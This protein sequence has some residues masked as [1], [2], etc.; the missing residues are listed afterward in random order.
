MN[1]I[2]C[3]IISGEIPARKLYEDGEFIAILDA[4]PSGAGHSLI[5]PKAH[6]DD[7]LDMD[8]ALA[9]RAFALASRLAKKVK[10]E[11]DC[12]GVNILQNNREAAGQTVGHFHVHVIPRH[13]GDNV[14]I[15]WGTTKMH[16]SEAD[17]V[18]QRLSF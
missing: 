11:L 18:S 3:K 15:K 13:P 12:E 10:A 5:I 14:T 9:G 16:E 6:V 7:V 2:F 17:E 8:D 4:F 1:C